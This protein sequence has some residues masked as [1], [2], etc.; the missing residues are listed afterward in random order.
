MAT[1]TSV[2]RPKFIENVGS[3]RGMYWIV[4]A[5]V[6][7]A[8]LVFIMIG[9]MIRTE[10]MRADLPPAQAPVI[11][12][13]PSAEPRAPTSEPKSRPNEDRVP[14]VEEP[15]IGSESHSGGVSM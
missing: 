13:I 11:Q 9:W 7:L 6:V 15:N 14:A 2:R 10:V 8:L 1:I 3:R 4:G 12:E 5:V